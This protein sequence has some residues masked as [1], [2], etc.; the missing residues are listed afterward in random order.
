M[1]IFTKLLNVLRSPSTQ[2]DPDMLTLALHGNPRINVLAVQCARETL[3]LIHKSAHA[4][5]V[6]AAVAHSAKYGVAPEQYLLDQLAAI[7]SEIAVFDADAKADIERRRE[8]SAKV[9]PFR[10]ALMKF[11]NG[12]TSHRARLL[13]QIHGVDKAQEASALAASRAGLTMKEMEH[14]GRFEPPEVSV[15][16]W[17]AQITEIDAQI[18]QIAAYS[19]DPL[20]SLKHLAG[21]PIPGFEQQLAG[22]TE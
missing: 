6:R 16:K 21:L 1:K 15:A 18:A 11:E 22:S 14:L 7:Q 20:K 19:A 17:R 5:F 12:L 9:H 8:E 3:Q 10:M 2:P 4:R 13:N